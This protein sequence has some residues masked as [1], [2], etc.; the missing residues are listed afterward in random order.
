MWQKLAGGCYLNA[1]L[2][3]LRK[4]LKKKAELPLVLSTRRNLLGVYRNDSLYERQGGK[5]IVSLTIDLEVKHNVLCIRLSGE[6]DHHTAEDLRQ[7]VTAI[8]ENQPINHIVLNLA[9]LS[10]MDS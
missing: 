9:K 4:H 2:V 7:K 8:L 1:Q 5:D 6:L 10:F 3:L